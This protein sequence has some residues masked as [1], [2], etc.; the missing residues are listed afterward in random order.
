[1][2]KIIFLFF[3]LI[4]IVAKSQTTKPVLVLSTGFNYGYKS[5][6]KNTENLKLNNR[7]SHNFSLGGRFFLKKNLSIEVGLGL[8]SVDPIFFIGKNNFSSSNLNATNIYSFLPPIYEFFKVYVN[9][10]KSYKI[11]TFKKSKFELLIG[12]GLQ[13][14]PPIYSNL[15]WSTNESNGTEFVSYYIFFDQEGSNSNSKVA[16]RNVIANSYLGI[17]YKPKILNKTFLSFE[18][19]WNPSF[20]AG[21][22]SSFVLDLPNKRIEGTQNYT[23]SNFGIKILITIPKINLKP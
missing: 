21:V 3:I 15:E 17:Q 13:Y 10:F 20:N 19:F 5:N 22:K 18:V 12:A 4:T 8:N 7:V 6:F 23:F 16:R 2:K 9:A 1:M 11:V 14:L